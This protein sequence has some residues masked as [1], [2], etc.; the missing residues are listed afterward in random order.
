M[1]NDLTRRTGSTATAEPAKDATSRFKRD[2]MKDAL[3]HVAGTKESERP[4]A[5]GNPRM[6]LALANH[7]HSPGWSYAVALERQAYAVARGLEMKFAC[8]GP[9]NAKGVRKLKITT[10]WISDA[11][12]MAG[13]MGRS[14]CECGCY[15]YIN[16]VL[17]Q[18]I[19]ENKDRPMRAAVIVGD[20]FHDD[21]D[22][23]AEA[24]LAIRKLQRQGTR[25]FLIQQGGNP[26]T[27]RKLQYLKQCA[28]YFKV[29][30]KTQ[31]LEE[32]LQ[33]I[34]V[35]AGAGEEAVKATGGQAATL[36]I[37][38]FKQQPMPIFDEARE[39][40]PVPVKRVTP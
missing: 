7:G 2:L 24:A 23:L 32:L 11:D 17:Q 22:G 1:G 39:P 21:E 30:P 15:V 8:W 9:D 5:A 29:G 4:I 34:S 28:A 3:S 40:V 33:A 25:V 18:A 12:K 13:L 31:Q 36:L 27:A 20:M 35:Y 6:L 38:H 10:D 26:L 19:E 16:N 37:E 14:K